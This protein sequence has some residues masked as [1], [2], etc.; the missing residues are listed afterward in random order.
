MK[1]FCSGKEIILKDSDF[2]ASGGEGSVYKKSNTIYKIYLSQIDKN[3]E[4]KLKDLSVLTKSNV[5]SPK[6]ILYS[7]KNDPIGYTM[8]F[9]SNSS[10]IALLFTNSFIFCY[11][12]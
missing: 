1:V 8:P 9:V 11:F 3:K 7:A 2:I 10:S 4:K 12:C 5:I 6:E